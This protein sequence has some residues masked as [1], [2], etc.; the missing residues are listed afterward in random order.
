VEIFL[1]SIEN[2][3]ISNEKFENGFGLMNL[4]VD[5]SKKITRKNQRLYK[6]KYL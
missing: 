1:K 4:S 3:W 6:K 5:I 2:E